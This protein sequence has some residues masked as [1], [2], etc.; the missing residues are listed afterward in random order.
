MQT[1]RTW[2]ELL[3]ATQFQL[4]HAKEFQ[5]GYSPF[6]LE[7][8]QQPLTPHTVLQGYYGCNPS[9]LGFMKGWKDRLEM[10]HISIDKCNKKDEALGNHDRREAEFQVGDLVL[11]KLG[12]R[13][14]SHQVACL[15]ALLQW[16][17]GPFKVLE[18]IGNVTYRL[19]LVR[20]HESSPSNFPHQSV[21]A[22]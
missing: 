20:P 11:L 7:N 17:E 18:K 15:G 19:E 16:F 2:L 12:E 1:N 13:N 9:T 6:E 4:Q 21:E 3:D 22:L 5:M 14:S 8:G 10:A